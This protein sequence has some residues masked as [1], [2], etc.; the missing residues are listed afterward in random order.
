MA[1]MLEMSLLFV[2]VCVFVDGVSKGLAFYETDIITR[3]SNIKK[4]LTADV[5]EPRGAG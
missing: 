2:A 1:N 5:I 4:R 3:Q